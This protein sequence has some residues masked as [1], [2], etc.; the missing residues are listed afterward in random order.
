MK[1]FSKIP[2]LKAKDHSSWI[3]FSITF[4]VLRKSILVPVFSPQVTVSWQ[5]TVLPTVWAVCQPCLFWMADATCPWIRWRVNP[6]PITLCRQCNFSSD[7]KHH[8]EFGWNC[9]MHVFFRFLHLYIFVYYRYIFK[10]DVHFHLCPKSP[11]SPSSVAF[12]YFFQGS[13]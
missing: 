13:S 8:N 10:F 7:W 5:F 6:Y 1:F 9:I 3:N 4:W 2:L 12:T 11:S